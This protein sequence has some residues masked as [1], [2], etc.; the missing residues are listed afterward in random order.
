MYALYYN[1]ELQLPFINVCLHIYHSTSD[2]PLD[3]LPKR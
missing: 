1:V 3:L 2:E